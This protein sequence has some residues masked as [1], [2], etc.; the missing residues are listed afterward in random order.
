MSVIVTGASGQL[1]RLVIDQLLATVP[2]T[3]VTAVVRDP[4]KVGDLA[5]RGVTLAVADYNSPE[6]FDGLLRGGDRVLLIS[7][8]E[9]HRDR[10]AQHKVVLGAAAKADV[11]LFAYTSAPGSQTGPVTDDHRATEDAIRASGIPYSLLRNSLYHEMVTTNIPAALQHGALTRAAGDGRLASASRAD[12]AAAAA[13]VMSGDGHEDTGDELTGDT[14]WS[15][16]E[17]AAEVSRQSGQHVPYRAVTGQ[18]Y[19]AMLSSAGL[20][21]PLPHVMADIDASIAA[22]EL[23]LATGDLSRLTGRST[24]PVADA[25]AA[26]LAG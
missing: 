21:D 24:T 20:P 15:F 23:A 1:G 14:A 12:Y 8:N 11:A 22:G 2:A 26:A 3:E 7:G 9:F 6:S 17:F 16:A 5:A 18:E 10:T 4:A 25:I 13:A 19:A